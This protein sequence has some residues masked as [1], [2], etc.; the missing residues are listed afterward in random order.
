MIRKSENNEKGYD[1]GEESKEI[2]DLIKQ[3]ISP[4]NSNSERES[5][6]PFEDSLS[7]ELNQRPKSQFSKCKTSLNLKLKREEENEKKEQS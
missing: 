5:Q 6:I 7:K 4:E 2:V 3:F 1:L